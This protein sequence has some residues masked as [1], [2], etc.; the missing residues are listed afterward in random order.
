MEWEVRRYWKSWV[1]VLVS[2]TR[3]KRLLVYAYNQWELLSGSKGAAK[4]HF[5]CK[6][7]LL[8]ELWRGN[9]SQKKK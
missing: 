3:P 7:A 9:K 1:L 5:P 2:L 4:L 6:A 8:R